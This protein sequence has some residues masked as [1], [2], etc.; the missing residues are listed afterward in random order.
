M[1]RVG[2][3]ARAGRSGTAYSLVTPDEY[4]YLLDLHLFLGKPMS[5]ITMENPQGDVG[6]MPQSLLEVQQGTL[7]NLHESFVDLVSVKYSQLR[8]KNVLLCLGK[9]AESN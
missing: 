7:I 8:K 6:R 2:R 9:Y 3:C 4:A 1:H 5:V